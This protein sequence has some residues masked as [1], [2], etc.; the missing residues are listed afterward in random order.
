[1]L[2]GESGESLE[3]RPYFG[4]GGYSNGNAKSK[5]KRPL[6][7]CFSSFCSG[8]LLSIE[9]A[10]RSMLQS[11]SVRTNPKFL[12]DASWGWG[13]CEFAFGSSRGSEEVGCVSGSEERARGRM[14]SRNAWTISMSSCSD[15]FSRSSKL[16]VLEQNSTNC[17]GSCPASMIFS[18]RYCCFAYRVL[19]CITTII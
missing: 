8:L 18:R 4:C 5:F 1:M 10:D 6:S 3:L 19:S 16:C 13:G 11:S 15:Q 17:S 7:V 2:G 9:G 12:P 14:W